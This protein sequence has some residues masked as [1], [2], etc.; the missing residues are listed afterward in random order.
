M[1]EMITEGNRVIERD[2][3][4]FATEERRSVRLH[5]EEYRRHGQNMSL[6]ATL[7]EVI[8]P[9]AAPQGTLVK[10][11]ARDVSN[12]VKDVSAPQTRVLST[13]ATDD[14]FLP[15]TNL[16]R[17]H[18]L[19]LLRQRGI[20]SDGEELRRS[21]SDT[22]LEEGELNFIVSSPSCGMINPFGKRPS[23]CEN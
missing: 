2:E 14:N 8:L 23:R 9:V 4:A 15:S 20:I 11:N 13:F 17:S 12:T 1:A 10:I 22:N 3:A 5:R 18:S 16:S 6:K 7:G 19:S 21:K